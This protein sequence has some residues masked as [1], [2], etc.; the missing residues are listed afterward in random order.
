MYINVNLL[1]IKFRDKMKI[2]LKNRN[3]SNKLK[4]L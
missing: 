1:V 4:Y 3:H 2:S